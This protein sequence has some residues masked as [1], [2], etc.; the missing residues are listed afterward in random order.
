[1]WWLETF[2]LDGLRID[3]VK[4]VEDSATRNLVA[5]VNQRFET[6]GTDYYL[7]GETAMGWVGHSLVDNQEQY[8]TINAYMGPDGLDGQADFVLYH[9]VVDN[10]FVSGNENYMHL[11]YWTNRSQDQYLEGSIMVPYVGSHDGPRLTSR[12][13]S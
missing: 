12:G 10:V 7:K 13:T 11:D 1:M 4:H 8:G 6:V 3:A 5:Q 9:A 2:D